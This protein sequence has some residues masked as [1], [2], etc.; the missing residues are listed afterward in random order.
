MNVQKRSTTRHQSMINDAKMIVQTVI[1][2]RRQ[3]W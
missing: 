3:S 2:E 1:E